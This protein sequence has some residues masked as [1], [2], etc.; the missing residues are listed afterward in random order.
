ML[1]TLKKFK[2]HLDIMEGEAEVA[3]QSIG[4]TAKLMGKYE[5]DLL[6]ECGEVVGPEVRRTS[7]MGRA[8]PASEA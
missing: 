6:T 8:V 5:L 2:E 3:N 1:L 4:E 7:Q